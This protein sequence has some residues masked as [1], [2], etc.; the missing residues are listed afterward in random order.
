MLFAA[1][2]LT[3]AGVLFAHFAADPIPPL[4]AVQRLPLRVVL[5]PPEKVGELTVYRGG[6][7]EGPTL[8]L[9]HGFGDS[10]GTWSQVVGPLARRHQVVVYD[11]PGHGRSGPAEPPLGFADLRLGIEAVA[12]TTDG[13]LVLVGNSLGGLVSL[14]FALDHPNRVQRVVLLNSGGLSAEKL[15]ASLLIPT[16]RDDVHRKNQALWGDR[17][18]SLP[19][20]LSDALM[21]HSADPRLQSLWI[22]LRTPPMHHVDEELGTLDVPVDVLWGTPDGILPFEGYGD[23][24]ERLLPDARTEILDGCAH[25]PQLTCPN[26]VV[27]VLEQRL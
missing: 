20:F 14:R 17:A 5:G 6:E 8:L 2:L 7:G 21:E 15:D 13:P 23:R 25:M 16:T 27:L 4:L 26:R 12:E 24:F 9:V 11:Q 18:R 10:A 1:V 19:G 22:D 3:V